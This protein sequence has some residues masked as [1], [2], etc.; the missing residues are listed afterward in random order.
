MKRTLMAVM[1][2]GSLLL[3]AALSACSGGGNEW[4]LPGFSSEDPTALLSS[5]RETEESNPAGGESSLPETAADPTVSE[6]EVPADPGDYDALLTENE[7]F[8][9]HY[10]GGSEKTRFLFRPS[11]TAAY[12]IALNGNAWVNVDAVYGDGSERPVISGSFGP[13]SRK[14]Q[15][16]DTLRYVPMKVGRTYVIDCFW[17]EPGDYEVRAVTL[18]RQVEEAAEAGAPLLTEGTEVRVEYD[19]TEE[20]GIVRFTP[21]TTGNYEINAGRGVYKVIVGEEGVYFSNG[22]PDDSSVKAELIGGNTYLIYLYNLQHKPVSLNVKVS[23]QEGKTFTPVTYREQDLSGGPLY[24]TVLI[25]QDTPVMKEDLI[26]GEKKGAISF[27]EE[28]DRSAGKSYV[29]IVDLYGE[30]V[31]LW[32]NYS[33]YGRDPYPWTEEI[34]SSDLN[35][36]RTRIGW[37]DGSGKGSTDLYG[38]L[39]YAGM[40]LDAVHA[41]YGNQVQTNI[42]LCSAGDVSSGAKFPIGKYSGDPDSNITWALENCCNAAFWMAEC[43]RS[44]GNRIHV[45]SPTYRGHE[46]FGIFYPLDERDNAFV[47]RF[48]K[49]ISDG[50]GYYYDLDHS[51]DAESSMKSIAERIIE[52]AK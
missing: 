24:Y 45:M 19:G 4:S 9:I 5:D 15:T 31:L 2:A 23:R 14:Y 30:N 26:A 46:S 33:K 41:T 22:H 44:K 32:E 29:A 13:D 38:A 49:D 20:S 42:V 48:M 17:D 51:G 21:G 34:F 3:P 40:L 35:V 1:L 11:E 16:G 28:L 25:F 10:D 27:C 6:P 8:E 43:V 7:V 39:N 37:I 18:K 52:T 36:L 50:D 12:S 47:S